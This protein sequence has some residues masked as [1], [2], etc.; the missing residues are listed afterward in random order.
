MLRGMWETL[1]SNI[2]KWSHPRTCDQHDG[3]EDTLTHQHDGS[4]DKIEIGAYGKGA[5]RTVHFSAFHSQIS[6]VSSLSLSISYL[7]VLTRV[8]SCPSKYGQE[9]CLTEGGDTP[10]VEFDPHNAI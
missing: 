10:S 6:C 3:S 8:T 4:E 5:T 7:P 9:A 2:E 1:F